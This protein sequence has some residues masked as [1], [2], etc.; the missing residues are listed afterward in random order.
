[1]RVALLAS[2]AILFATPAWAA[3]EPSAISTTGA[4]SDRNLI[5]EMVG[6]SDLTGAGTGIKATVF[7]DVQL[8]R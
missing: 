1:M 2:T 6:F 3:D 7:R 4:A 5:G 8:Y